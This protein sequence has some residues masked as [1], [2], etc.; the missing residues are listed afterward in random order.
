M[1][2]PTVQVT[3]NVLESVTLADVATGELPPEVLRL[4]AEPEVWEPH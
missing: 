1:I 2:G 4:T 3:A